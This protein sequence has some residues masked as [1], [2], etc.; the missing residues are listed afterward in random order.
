M[1]NTYGNV[2]I[3][4]VNIEENFEELARN[5][6]DHMRK[7][8]L[9]E[10]IDMGMEPLYAT[11]ESIACSE[12]CYSAWDKDALLSLFGIAHGPD[13]TYIWMLATEDVKKH[14]KELVQCGLDF[15][16]DSLK[17]YGPLCNYISTKNK[18]ALRF[19]K[20]AGAHFSKPMYLEN[21]TEFVRFELEV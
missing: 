6:A 12:I 14:K 11:Q 7:E 1:N 10:Q 18:P 13:E 19:I 21:G 4:E 3:Q 15:I 16:K 20:R 9:I 5:L 2:T 17:T 8:D